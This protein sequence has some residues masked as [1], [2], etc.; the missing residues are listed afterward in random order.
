MLCRRGRFSVAPFSDTSTGVTV[1]CLLFSL[2]RLIVR[3]K[4]EGIGEENSQGI[5]PRRTRCRGPF[6]M[7]LLP[8]SSRSAPCTRGHSSLTDFY[9]HI[10]LC[11]FSVCIDCVLL[12]PAHLWSVRELPRP[13]GWRGVLS[14]ACPPPNSNMEPL[15]FLCAHSSLPSH[16]NVSYEQLLGALQRYGSC[17]QRLGQWASESVEFLRVP[18]LLFIASV[19]EGRREM[20]LLNSR[21]RSWS[22]CSHGSMWW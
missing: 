1:W 6:L 15:S 8:Q 22:S 10:Y 2:F 14:F 11:M 9:T 20:Q 16:K 21:C 3:A 13:V 7:L 18:P 19:P 5:N 12:Q 4:T 17:H